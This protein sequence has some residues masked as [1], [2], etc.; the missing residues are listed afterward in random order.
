MYTVNMQ[1]TSR[2][3]LAVTRQNGDVGKSTIFTIPVQNDGRWTGYCRV[4]ESTNHIY[5]EVGGATIVYNKLLETS[6]LRIA[7]AKTVHLA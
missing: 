6:L 1:G 3:F 5:L 4:I 2:T 7:L